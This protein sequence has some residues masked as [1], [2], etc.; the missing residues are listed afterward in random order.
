MGLGMK[1]IISFIILTIYYCSHIHV[2]SN[3]YTQNLLHSFAI[4]FLTDSD[5]QFSKY[6]SQMNKHASIRNRKQS[7]APKRSRT[8]QKAQGNGTFVWG[9]ESSLLDI[10]RAVNGNYIRLVELI[11]TSGL[12]IHPVSGPTGRNWISDGEQGS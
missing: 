8:F 2:S 12:K 1:K 11:S 9:E 10:L 7:E 6:Y 5:S 3:F 4:K